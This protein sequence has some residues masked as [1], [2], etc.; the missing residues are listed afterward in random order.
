MQSYQKKLSAVAAAAALLAGIGVAVA[1]TNQPADPD[2]AAVTQTS[3]N[4]TSVTTPVNAD[5]HPRQTWDANNNANGSSTNAAS[6]SAN[7]SSSTSS[8]APSDTSTTTSTNTS[9]TDNSAA[10]APR[11]DRN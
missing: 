4:D 2:T 6:N 5:S 8:S 7:D 3:P 10:P 1:Q 11:A 9:S